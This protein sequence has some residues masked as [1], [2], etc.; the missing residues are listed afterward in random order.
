MKKRTTIN[1]FGKRLAYYRKAKGLTQKQLGDQIEVS[2]RVIAY[3]EGETNYPP[4]HLIVPLAKALEITTDE[5]LGVTETRKDF[6][7][8]N[9]ALRRKLKVVESLPQRDR[10]AI[11]HY[12]N[13]ISKTRGI[14]QKATQSK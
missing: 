3:Y 1:G 2:N 10:K 6:D 11:M 13:M 12:I 9:T 4:A 8:R 7:T 14:H 5:L